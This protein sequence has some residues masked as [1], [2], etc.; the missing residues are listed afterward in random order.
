MMQE[1]DFFD[2]PIQPYTVL[3]DLAELDMHVRDTET[4]EQRAVRAII[5]T[6]AAKLPPGQSAVLNIYG[7][8]GER[9]RQ[10]WYIHILGDLNEEA[11]GTDHEMAQS[12]DM[13]QSMESTEQFK[14][15]KYRKPKGA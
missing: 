10:E 6:S 15:S 13:E 11:L 12:L 2:T 4:M 1:Y 3:K 9:I 8:L 5:A 7:R 14:V